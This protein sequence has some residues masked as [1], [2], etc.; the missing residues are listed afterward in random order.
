MTLSIQDEFHLFAEELQ[1]YLSP[2][3]LQQLAQETGF[4]KRKSKYG[5]RELTALCIW[6]SQHVASDSLTRLCS[7]LYANTATLISPEGLNQRFNRYAVLFL[8]RVFSL[9][10][11]SK[12]ND[13]SQISNQY[14][15]YFQRIRIL[16]A[17][18]FQVPNHFTII[19]MFSLKGE[20][21]VSLPL[22]V[23]RTAVP[24][25]IYFIVMFSFSSSWERKLG[26]IIL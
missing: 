10:V 2:N 22:D 5:A 25:R 3:I 21:I 14:T 15:S 18:I 13:S 4:V 1:R 8:Q 17:T 7:R 23:V 6:I 12:L 26:P 16:D 9:L 19:I 11:K 20:I 24:L